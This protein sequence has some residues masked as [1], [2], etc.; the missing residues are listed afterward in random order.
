MSSIEL[1][2]KA[3]KV[4]TSEKIRKEEEITERIPL[5]DTSGPTEADIW[6]EKWKAISTTEF[7]EFVNEEPTYVTDLITDAENASKS[8]ATFDPMAALLDSFI[9]SDPVATQS[10]IITRELPEV[11][12]LHKDFF[13]KNPWLQDNMQ[14][15]VAR[16][17][18]LKIT[19]EQLKIND[20]IGLKQDVSFEEAAIL[21][22][23]MEALNNKIME[24]NRQLEQA[25]YYLDLQKLR[26]R[27]AFEEL[28][29]ED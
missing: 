12:D 25:K 15:L 24:A 2:P 3:I 18:G 7:S 9:I 20:E 10:S 13:M 28:T 4:E 16:L 11:P 19:L 17:E 6:R 5:P 29:S 23:H 26:D 1:N 27:M 22:G 8:G 21:Q 14:P